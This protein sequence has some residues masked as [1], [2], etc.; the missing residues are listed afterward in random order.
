VDT[1][2]LD[3]VRRRGGT[4]DAWPPR[5]ATTD[6]TRTWS[7]PAFCDPRPPALALPGGAHADH[8]HACATPKAVVTVT[9]R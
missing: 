3:S 1:N 9:G 8:D 2:M 6:T 4:L 5:E 7:Y